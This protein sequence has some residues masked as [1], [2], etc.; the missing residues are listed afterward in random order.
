MDAAPGDDPGGPAAVLPG[1]IALNPYE[2][3]TAAAVFERLFPADESGPG[4]TEIGVIAYLDRAL[5]GEYWEQVEAY[6]VGLAT[7]DRI[8]RQRCGRPFADC[9]PEQQDELIAGLEQGAL[10]NFRVPPQ[11]EF[12]AKLRA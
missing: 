7:L 11:R 8:A 3:R 4:A 10:P 5:A 12:F 1:L 6:R 2:A 9:A